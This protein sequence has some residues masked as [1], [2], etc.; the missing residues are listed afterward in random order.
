VYWYKVRVRQGN[1]EDYSYVGSIEI[2]PDELAA[3]LSSGGWIRI[4]TLLQ[5]DGSEFHDWENWDSAVE[6]V[7]YLSPQIVVAFMQLKN[8]PRLMS[9]EQLGHSKKGILSGIFNRN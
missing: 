5:W 8:D 2:A 9:A 4:N 1:G 7:L 3:R 6:P